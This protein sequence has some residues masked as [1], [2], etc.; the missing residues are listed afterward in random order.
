MKLALLLTL[1]LLA[2]AYGRPNKEEADDGPEELDGGPVEGGEEDGEGSYEGPEGPE[3]HDEEGGPHY[4]DDEGYEGYDEEAPANDEN[5]VAGVKDKEAAG[6]F[7]GFN[8]YRRPYRHYGHHFRRHHHH[9]NGGRYVDRSTCSVQASY[10]LSYNGDRR[11]CRYATEDH[12]DCQAC[13]EAAT[14]RETRNAD[15]D[16]IIGFITLNHRHGNRGKREAA[17]A[18]GGGDKSYDEPKWECV[19]CI[20]KANAY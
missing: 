11:Y 13:C 12:D 17:Y 14:R 6:H 18:A 15:K 19:C 4:D 8:G 2:S 7:G 3:G 10:F 1:C 5:Q 20:P 9:G 16:D